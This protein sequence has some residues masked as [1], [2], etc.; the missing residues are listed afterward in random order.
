MAVAP[1][2]AKITP[3]RRLSNNL[4]NAAAFLGLF[5]FSDAGIASFNPVPPRQR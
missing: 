3:P 4:T 5:T 1:I 2:Y